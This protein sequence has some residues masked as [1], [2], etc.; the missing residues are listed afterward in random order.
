MRFDCSEYRR[1]E[2]TCQGLG[3]EIFSWLDTSML[4]KCV[5]Y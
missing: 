4:V 5:N 2:L 1:K 3:E